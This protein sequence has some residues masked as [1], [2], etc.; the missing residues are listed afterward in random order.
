MTEET[1][2]SSTTS[3]NKGVNWEIKN[4]DFPSLT[5]VEASIDWITATSKK[6]E[7]LRYWRELYAQYAS[8][9]YPE[10]T[11]PD[12]FKSHG[13]T[14]PSVPG[15]VFATH[16]QHGALIRLSG[17]G[18]A[19]AW[20]EAL[21]RVEYCN[22]T[23]IDLC[24]TVEPK[25]RMTGIAT[26]EY[27]S[28]I[29]RNHQPHINKKLVTSSDGG[30]TMYIGSRT[31]QIFLRLYDKSA[32]QGNDPGDKWRYEVEYKKPVAQQIAEMIMAYAG[33][34]LTSTTK[35]VADTVFNAFSQRGV[36]PIF[37][38]DLETVLPTRAKKERSPVEAQMRWLAVSV[39]PAVRRLVAA[40]YGDAIREMLGLDLP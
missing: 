37:S 25:M 13:Y 34:K 9:F 27:A 31:S 16:P 35:V 1:R 18:A 7:V 11:S 23:R 26:N 28:L 15:F 21:S 22:V 10:I 40:G 36:K 6:E 33:S 24:V 32:E 12:I 19:V 2:S 14:G 20:R 30:E 8:D 4:S 5:M 29:A 3:V 17:H 38:S 39:S